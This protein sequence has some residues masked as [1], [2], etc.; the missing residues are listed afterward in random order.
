MKINRVVPIVTVTLITAAVVLLIVG[1]VQALPFLHVAGDKD[2]DHIL[3]GSD[4]QPNVYCA[5]GQADVNGD[6]FNSVPNDL[7]PVAGALGDEPPQPLKDMN[8][9]DVGDIMD[10]RSVSI[11][12]FTFDC[13]S[14]TP[15]PTSNPGLGTTSGPKISLSGPTTLNGAEVSVTVT[16][17][18]SGVAPAY[19]GYRPLR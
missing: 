6:G 9:N 13:T 10:I 12:L 3:D 7:L 2:G 16:V 15:D 1:S 18:T 11:A 17:S 14:T 5:A 8:H 4:P 19:L